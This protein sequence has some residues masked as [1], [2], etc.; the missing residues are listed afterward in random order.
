MAL[1]LYEYRAVIVSVYDGD[2]VRADI[3]CGFGI[4][5]RNEPLR[6]YGIDT[7][8]IRGAEREQGLLARDALARR[9]LQREVELRTIKPSTKTLPAQEVRDKY[10]RYLAV[11]W[12][13]Q[14][15]VNEWLVEQG[16]AAPY[17]V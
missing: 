7:P 11:I 15:N 5:K 14:G 3:D 1:T 9:I 16:F 13:A 2:T 8:E 4:W 10:G 17:V 12:D 6:L